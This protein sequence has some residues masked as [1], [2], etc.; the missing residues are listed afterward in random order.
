MN[1]I[2]YFF[3]YCTLLTA[4]MSTICLVAYLSIHKTGFL[5]LS[6]V[7]AFMSVLF[8]LFGQGERELTYYKIQ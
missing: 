7:L 4:L 5:A 3:E 8:S 6:I 2:L 1:E